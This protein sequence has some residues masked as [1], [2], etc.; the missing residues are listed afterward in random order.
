MASTWAHHR[1]PRPCARR[2]K[3]DHPSAGAATIALRA[4][5]AQ[6]DEI[7][8]VVLGAKSDS[9]LHLVDDVLDRSL[10]ACRSRDVFDR[11]TRRT[12]QMMMVLGQVLGELVTSELVVRHDAMD[13]AGLFEHDEIPIDGALG[14]A[15][16]LFQDFGDRQRSGRGSQDV[17]QGFAFRG[18]PL[19]GAS[20]PTG[21]RGT[22]IGVARGH[23]RGV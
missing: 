11:T 7:D 18:E 2:R 19:I 15:A 17:D 5:S 6:T 8:A 3:H 9:A 12:D 14:K 4:P 23:G 10:E 22:K 13:D 21:H 1:S 20:Q 16:P